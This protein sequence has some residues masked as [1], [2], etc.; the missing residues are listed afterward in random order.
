MRVLDC[1][2]LASLWH[3]FAFGAE[4]GNICA[5]VGESKQNDKLSVFLG[6]CWTATRA[7]SVL[8]LAVSVRVCEGA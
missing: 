8:S 4:D 1:I 7:T 5:C 3:D 6:I 2:S